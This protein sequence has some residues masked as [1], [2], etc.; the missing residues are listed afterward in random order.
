[1][2]MAIGR[3]RKYNL[4]MPSSKMEKKKKKKKCAINQFFK[5]I[6]KDNNIYNSPCINIAS[7]VLLKK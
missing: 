4:T 2:L 5:W 1:M 7:F 6:Q 3:P